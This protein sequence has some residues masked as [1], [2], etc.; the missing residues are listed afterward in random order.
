[1]EQRLDKQFD[2]R[3]VLFSVLGF[4]LLLRLGIGVFVFNSY[5]TFWY[6]QWIL[7]LGNGF[8]DI[9]ARA[10][11]IALDYPPLFLVLVYP[12]SLLYKLIPPNTYAMAD[13]LFLKLIP[14]LFD[15]ATA[16]LFYAMGRRLHSAEAGIFAA[17]IWALNPSMLFNSSVWGQTDSV[18]CFL[19]LLAFWLL[20]TEH[21]VWCTVVLAAACMIKFQCLFF[22]P[23]YLL[24]IL[25][26]CN[27]STGTKKE[28]LKSGLRTLGIC[29][30]VGVATVAAVFLP[31]A[32]ASRDL[33]LFPGIY[34][35]SGG[36]YPYCTLNA[37]NFFGALKLNWVEYSTPAFGF[38]TW[39][40]VGYI[41]T[42]MGIILLVAAW[43]VAKRRCVFVAS[44]FIMQHIFM[45]MPA[46]HE[47]YQV[48]V[49]PF[50]LAAWLIHKDSRF[51]WLT[52]AL[53][54]I[55]FINQLMVLANAIIGGPLPWSNNFDQW[56]MILSLINLGIYFWSA[57]VC[58]LFLVKDDQDQGQNEIE[59]KE[60]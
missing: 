21:P 9:Y 34:F 17:S 31:F 16:W 60:A 56:M 2:L 3:L 22:A 49:L 46:M 19:L 38:L 39:A 40:H 59:I 35:S 43:V 15:V 50:C 30:A 4:S 51:G 37:Y 58:I 44:L 32:L 8:F 11:A 55:T 7:D 36:K 5:D 23:V 12:I 20:T 1:M 13:M 24:G 52:A 47:R 57:I 45:F 6:R 29:A 53:C 10:D 18:M 28:D 48:A 42:A 41:L 27:I 54:G 14:I 26:Y 25:D 33:T